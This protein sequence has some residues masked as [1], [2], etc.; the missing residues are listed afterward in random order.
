MI[1]SDRKTFSDMVIKHDSTWASIDEMI[2]WI[3]NL[4]ITLEQF[5]KF[6]RDN[7]ILWFYNKPR[8]RGYRDNN[9]I[10]IDEFRK[11]Q[12]EMFLDNSF[13]D[14][15]PYIKFQDDDEIVLTVTMEESDDL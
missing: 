15:L 4:D 6:A 10:V 2:E 8:W 3:D 9:P 5:K 1:K 11:F 14:A 12:E 7:D 13:N